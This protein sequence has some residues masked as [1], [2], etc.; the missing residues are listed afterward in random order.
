MLSFFFLFF[1]I[2]LK[3]NFQEL[4][5]TVISLMNIFGLKGRI[6]GMMKYVWWKKHERLANNL[7]PASMDL[8]TLCAYC[9][10]KPILPHTMSCSHIFCY[11][12]LVVI[13][14]SIFFMYLQYY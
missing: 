5:G 3:N 1:N 14:Y 9:S 6:S 8:N 7:G 10:S 2:Q 13:I 4:I 11:Y 12:C